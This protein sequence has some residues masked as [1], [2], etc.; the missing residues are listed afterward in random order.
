MEA[1]EMIRN[2]EDTAALPDGRG[3]RFA[4]YAVIGLPFRSE[5]VLAMRRFPASSVGAGY[6]SVWHRS[7]EG[8][9]T[10][11]STVQPELGCSRYFGG[12]I[13]QNVMT[14]IEIV[15]SGAAVF[16]VLIA[17]TLDWEVT[18]TESS[19]SRLMN[20]VARL[21]PER[22]WQAEPMLRAM[23]YAAR[24]GLGSGRLNLTG[25]TPNGQHFI[26]NPRRFWLIDSSR[27]AIKGVDAGPVG[28]LKQ[29]ASLSD[30]LIPQ[31]G[32][33]AVARAFLNAPAGTRVNGFALKNQNCANAK[34]R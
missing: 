34:S 14:P 19:T 6:T 9:W 28:A 12:E 20:G 7:P 5:H 27:A 26:A 16:R 25:T 22:W 1:R 21:L 29:Q 15:W 2:I 13:Q 33:F 24:I 18:L 30:F 17:E 10:F 3:D 11:Y 32:I 4:G 8:K 23:G 31:R